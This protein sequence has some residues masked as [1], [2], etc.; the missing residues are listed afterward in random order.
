MTL[1]KITNKQQSILLLL[2]RF[3]FLNRIQIQI[4]Q[5][6]KYPKRIND[7]LKDLTQKEYLGR[8]YS[9]K[10]GEINKPAIYYLKLNGI[11][12]LK[13]LNCSAEQLKNL[14]HEENKSEN[15]I[16]EQLLIADICLSLQQ[17]NNNKIKYAAATASDLSDPEYKFNFLAELG[18][19][20]IYAKESE[21]IKKYYLLEIFEP[22]IPAY[23]VRKKIKNYFDFY[24]SNEWED[25]MD[26]NF[27]TILFICPTMPMLISAK[28]YSK[29]LLSEYDDIDLQIKLAT[30][31]QAKENGIISEI[32]EIVNYDKV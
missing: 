6:H 30:E 21:G 10:Y 27:P 1:Q 15:F 9:T 20:L 28:R 16:S 5:K 19:D 23:S 8:I 24:F 26:E 3:R 31:Q 13:T 29:K 18:S 14:Y 32:W 17:K 2:F 4:L 12:Y 7:W 25:K 22:T 11:R